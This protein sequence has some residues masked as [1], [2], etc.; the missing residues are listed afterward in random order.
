MVTDIGRRY[1]LNMLSDVSPKGE[2]RLILHDGTV[3]APIF[4]TF[5]QRLMV[6]ATNTVFV[7]VDGEPVYKSA[8]VRQYIESQASKL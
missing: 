3:T 5:L 4:K 2:F 7:Q 8:L 1:S 6:G